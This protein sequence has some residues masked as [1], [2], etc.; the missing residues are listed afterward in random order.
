MSA[1]AIA[2]IGSS[3]Q[4]RLQ[5]LDRPVPG[6]GEILLRVHAAAVARTD[7]LLREGE[8]PGGGAFPRIL[9]GEAAG[10]I[11]EV[12]EGAGGFEPGQRVLVFSDRVGRD[13][14]GTYAEFV[15]VPA[16]DVHVI[17]DGLGFVS[18]A[19][20]GRPFATAWVALLEAAAL[21][22]T[23]EFGTRER[24]VV[25]AA[26]S[27]VGTAAIQIARWKGATV[28]AISSGT[29][30]TR[31]MTLGAQRVVSRS[32]EDLVER[33]VTAFGGH[34]ATLIL[35][36]VGRDTLRSSV[37]MLEPRGRIVCVGTISGELAEIDAAALI[38][39]RATIR[40]GRGRI[41]PD[42]LQRILTLVGEGTFFPV[43]DSILPLSAARA[44]HQRVES[45]RSFGKVLLIPDAL[46]HSGE[47]LGQ[48]VVKAG[49]G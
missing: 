28:V 21:G 37:A 9:G 31:L 45:R 23:A 39:K 18:A 12:G 40:G 30:A 13:R 27:G 49:A 32:A 16:G 15:V 10:V 4:L 7:V 26:S 35:D 19:A 29:K 14:P 34:R 24:L 36:L 1:V 47:D 41:E 8:L 33:V 22:A 46:Y 3:D 43:I 17:P 6:P 44:A 25:S 2:G 42:D 5:P 11:T 38:Q 48:P 20:L